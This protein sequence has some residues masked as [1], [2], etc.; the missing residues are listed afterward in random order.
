MRVKLVSTE[1]QENEV[2]IWSLTLGREYEVIAIEAD[3]YRIVDDTNLPYLFSPD[4]F[5]I[6]DPSEPTFWES[7]KGEEGERYCCP[8]EWNE[9]GFFE[10]FFERNEETQ[11][12]FWA[13]F[14]IY[15]PQLELSDA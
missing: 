3:M 8:P 14:S 6:V 15:F 10:D 11:R 5:K 4:C 1:D 13:T 7:E 2:E 12:V 9:P